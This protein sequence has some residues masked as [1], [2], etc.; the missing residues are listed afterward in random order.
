MNCPQVHSARRRAA[1]AAAAA[2][3][4]DTPRKQR[5]QQKPEASTN[6][7]Q[8][9]NQTKSTGQPER[10]A[11]AA[12]AP[13]HER[14]HGAPQSQEDRHQ[15]QAGQTGHKQPTINWNEHAT[16]PSFAHAQAKIEQPPC[17]PES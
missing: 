8:G 10:G 6:P 13:K 2:A 9:K 14:R 11:D 7:N 16:K 5:A 15:W 12:P 3:H 1:A 4:A 17:Q